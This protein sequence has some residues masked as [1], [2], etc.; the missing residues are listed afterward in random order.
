MPKGGADMKIIGITPELQKTLID[1]HGYNKQTI[2]GL[3]VIINELNEKATVNLDHGS[4]VQ[5]IVTKL[6]INVKE[7]ETVLGLLTQGENRL[8][9]TYPTNWGTRLVVTNKFFTI[10]GSKVNFTYPNFLKR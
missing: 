1:N 10:T 4:V 3:N 6:G 8:F 7:A 9:D 5:G 2:A